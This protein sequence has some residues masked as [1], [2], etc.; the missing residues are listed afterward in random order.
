MYVACLN[1]I[2]WD[3]KSLK[4]I[5]TLANAISY[6]RMQ[7]VCFLSF[8]FPPLTIYKKVLVGAKKAKFQAGES[9]PMI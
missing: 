8:R 5:H 3:R 6:V 1:R 2:S 4:S 7:G 9:E